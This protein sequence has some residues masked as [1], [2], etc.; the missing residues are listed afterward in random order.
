MERKIVCAANKFYFKNNLPPIVICGL[1]HWDAI[2]HMAV[3][4]F[5]KELWAQRDREAETQG[6]IDTK[7]VFLDRREAWEVANAAGQIVRRCGGDDHKLF[8]EN[9]Y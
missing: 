9:L 5:D 6:F 3:T 4:S 2:M 7:G 1:R 8:S